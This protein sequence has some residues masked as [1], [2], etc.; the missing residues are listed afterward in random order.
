MFGNPQ[1]LFLR[2]VLQEKIQQIAHIVLF[3]NCLHKTGM[4]IFFR[5]FG[6]IIRFPLS[7]QMI[8]VSQDT[9]GMVPVLFELLCL[10][11]LPDIAPPGRSLTVISQ[12]KILGQLLGGLLGG[13][14]V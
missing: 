3:L 4:G 11:F 10:G 12:A 8:V 14:I 6:G 7:Q 2:A 9:K 1:L 5:C 13:Q